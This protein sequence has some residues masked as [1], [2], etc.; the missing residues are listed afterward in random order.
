VKELAAALGARIEKL[1]AEGGGED[2]KEL[3]E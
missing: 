3:T 1:E 2:K